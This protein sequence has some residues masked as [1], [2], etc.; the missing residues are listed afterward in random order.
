M[1]NDMT[2]SIVSAVLWF[3]FL[4][5]VLP[6]PRHPPGLYG[7]GLRLSSPPNSSSGVI[8]AFFALRYLSHKEPT[9]SPSITRRPS[10]TR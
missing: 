10:W 6:P 1:S 4:L 8:V 5:A 3:G 9:T 7:L 2:L